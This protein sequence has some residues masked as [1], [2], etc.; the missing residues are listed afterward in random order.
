[1]MW[2]LLVGVAMTLDDLE[3]V[4]LLF[5]QS[6]RGISEIENAG[7]TAENFHE[8]SYSGVG[9]FIVKVLWLFS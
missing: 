6:L 8:V 1:M 9:L 3:E 5:T 4:D 2:K 7:V